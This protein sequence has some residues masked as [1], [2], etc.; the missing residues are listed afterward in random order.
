MKIRVDF[1][2]LP[3][4][5][6]VVGSKSITFDFSGRTIHDLIKE[7]GDKYGPKVA[8]FLLDESGQLDMILKIILNDKEWIYRQQME[9]PLKDGDKVTIMMLAAG[10]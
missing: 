3:T 6:K 10:G 2:S 9:H 5:I 7:L 1:L 4:V 8:D